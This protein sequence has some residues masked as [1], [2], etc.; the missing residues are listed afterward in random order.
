M[1][2]LIRLILREETETNMFKGFDV[3]KFKNQDPPDNES[4]ETKKEIK[5]L[6]KFLLI[7]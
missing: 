4:E 7:S 3:S 2:D 6:L 5:Y 1:K